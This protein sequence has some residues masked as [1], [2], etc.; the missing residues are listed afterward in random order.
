MGLLAMYGLFGVLASQ[1]YAYFR[2]FPQ[3]RSA[4]KFLVSV[5][6][7]TE[8]L[9]TLLI[10]NYGTPA[11]LAH[12]PKTSAA[13]LVPTV[14]VRFIVQVFFSY[15]IWSLTSSKL[16]PCILIPLNVTS[17]A[18]GLR[19]T[20]HAIGMTSFGEYTKKMSILIPTAF[21]I[22]FAVDI[23]TSVALCWCTVMMCDKIMAWAIQTGIVTSI[24]SAL[25]LVTFVTMRRNFIWVAFYILLPKLY[26]NSLVASLNGRASLRRSENDPVESG[27][28]SIGGMYFI[29]QE[30]TFQRS[31][32]IDSE[33]A[34]VSTKANE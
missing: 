26:S 29:M 6:C 4:L 5:F 8:P 10:T 34:V 28:V 23:L 16:V 32:R 9:Y 13:L 2:T 30:N 3:D 7:A 21:L 22:A 14:A 12:L 24:A 33:S 27:D 20:V 1:T 25:V 17:A 18:L 19:I 31:T 15:R 11:A